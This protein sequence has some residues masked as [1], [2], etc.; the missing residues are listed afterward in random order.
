LV[1]ATLRSRGIATYSNDNGAET[2]YGYL[3]DWKIT[4][5]WG[6]LSTILFFPMVLIGF[7]IPFPPLLFGSSIAWWLFGVA[8]S[9]LL[10]IFL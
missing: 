1:V 7:G 5:I 3:E 2:K 4:V 10:L 8:F 9:G 6:V